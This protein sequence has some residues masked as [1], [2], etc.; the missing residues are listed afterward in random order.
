MNSISI[1][2]KPKDHQ[3][4]RNFHEMLHLDFTMDEQIPILRHY[5][6]LK[7]IG[8]L[9][10]C[11]AIADTH[12]WLNLCWRYGISGNIF[13]SSIVPREKRLELVGA[14]GVML[15]NTKLS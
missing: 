13:S 5:F 8:R 7:M 2:G 3:E 4:G 14:G 11:V 1:E 15:K 6:R 10:V 9:A 12:Y